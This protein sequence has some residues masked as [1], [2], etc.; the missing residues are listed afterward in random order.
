MNDGL[1]SASISRKPSRRL[2]RSASSGVRHRMSRVLFVLEGLADDVVVELGD[3]R[4]QGVELR[5]TRHVL[6][7]ALG[8]LER[9]L[10]EFDLGIGQALAAVDALLDRER[11]RQPDLREPLE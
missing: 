11:P 10:Q 7:P 8:I 2:R 4:A 6:L 5:I 1:T 3:L 9:A